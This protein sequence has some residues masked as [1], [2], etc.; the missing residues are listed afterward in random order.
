MKAYRALTSL[1]AAVNQLLPLVERGLGMV[2]PVELQDCTS[3]G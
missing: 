1:A 2:L 3:R